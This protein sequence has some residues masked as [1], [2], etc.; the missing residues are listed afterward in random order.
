MALGRVVVLGWRAMI[1][2][3]FRRSIMFRR[4]AA[5]AFTVIIDMGR[6]MSVAVDRSRR[7]VTGNFGVRRM[8]TVVR[9]RCRRRAGNGDCFDM[10]FPIL[11]AFCDSSGLA[12][13]GHDLGDMD[14]FVF[15]VDRLMALSTHRGTDG[16]GDE[17]RNGDLRGR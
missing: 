13:L 12:G 9:S 7:N 2:G 11:L 10:T 6:A 3:T 14:D 5:M 15:R 16:G 17:M 8:S 4:R 1:S